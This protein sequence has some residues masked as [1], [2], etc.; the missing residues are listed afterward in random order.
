ML[1]VVFPPSKETFSRIW[2][3]SIWNATK[4]SKCSCACSLHVLM[5]H[6][7]TQ[8]SVSCIGFQLSTKLRSRLFFKMLNSLGP[9]YLWDCVSQYIPQ[10]VLCLSDLLVICLPQSETE[11]F[12]L[13]LQPSGPPSQVIRA[14]KKLFQFHRACKTEILDLWLRR[15]V[16]VY[17]APS[18]W[19]GSLSSQVH[20]EHTYFW[21]LG[22]HCLSIL[23]AIFIVEMF[24]PLFIHSCYYHLEPT[25]SL[26]SGEGQDRCSKI[27]LKNRFW[28]IIWESDSM[29][30]YSNDWLFRF[31]FA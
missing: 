14:L 11:P 13:L 30:Y 12:W 1:Q 20:R 29:V 6:I 8:C 16:T 23:I 9:T 15:W 28:Y 3:Q 17:L 5:T 25:L 21:D 31:Y 24:L 18:W 22:E 2:L 4:N 27:K 7:I 19:W 10:R 26:A